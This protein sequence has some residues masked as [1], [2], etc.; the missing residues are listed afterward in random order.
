MNKYQHLKAV[1]QNSQAGFTLIELI[2]VIVILGILAAT[3]LPKFA[4]LGKDARYA[5]LNAAKGSLLTVSAM[6]HGKYLITPAST[7]SLESTSVAMSTGNG[8]PTAVA[9]LATAAGLDSTDYIV[10]PPG[11]AGDV[12]TPTVTP[13]EVAFI[14]KS[15]NGTTVGKTCF[16]KYGNLGTTGTIPTVTVPTDSTSC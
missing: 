6:A 13:N 4:D 16:V 3:A 2:V 8:F 10:V 12:N 14:P 9:A 1:R 7:I 15:V 11:N 5:S